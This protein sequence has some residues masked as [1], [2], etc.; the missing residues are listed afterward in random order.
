MDIK[1]SDRIIPCTLEEQAEKVTEEWREFRIEGN[2]FLKGK[3]NN[4][5]TWTR[6]ERL[7][8]EAFDLMEALV[9]FLV[10]AGIDVVA[11]NE[12]HLEKMRRR[13]ASGK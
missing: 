12:R 11:A 7:A 3:A 4:F 5:V 10:K 13:E 6:Y 1:L 2:T 9:R 8:E